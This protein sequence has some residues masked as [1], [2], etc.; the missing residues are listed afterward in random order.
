MMEDAQ[1]RQFGPDG[2]GDTV[3]AARSSR[4]YPALNAIASESQL[5]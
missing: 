2:Q 5:G 3:K 1:A 4:R